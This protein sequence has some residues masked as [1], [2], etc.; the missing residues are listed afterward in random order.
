MI[1]SHF[2]LQ[3]Y[4]FLLGAYEVKFHSSTMTAGTESKSE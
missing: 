3:A 1:D 2:C 4:D